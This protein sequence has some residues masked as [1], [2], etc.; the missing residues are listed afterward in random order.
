MKIRK[1]SS[2]DLIKLHTIGLATPEFKVGAKGEFME[3]DEF[4]SAIENPNG[5]FLLAEEGQE[6]VGFIYASR[7]DV[8]RGPRTKWACLVYLVVKPKYRKQRVAQQL[9][10]T[11]VEELRNHGISSIYAWANIESDNSIVK[12][13]EKQRFSRGHTYVW[14]DK[15]LEGSVG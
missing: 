4:L 3:Q 15:T 1:A 13:L 12:F 10:G 2:Q 5:T 9:Y 7:K 11:C 14:M 8:E 6:V